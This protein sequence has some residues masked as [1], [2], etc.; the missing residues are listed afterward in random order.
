M[1]LFQHSAKQ[2]NVLPGSRVPDDAPTLA[3]VRRHP[4]LRLE[5]FLGHDVI[6]G[7]FYFLAS[8][9]VTKLPYPKPVNNR[10]GRIV[11][12]NTRR[13]GLA[14]LIASALIGAPIS[15]QE[16]GGMKDEKGMIKDEKDA[17]TKDKMKAEKEGSSRKYR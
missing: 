1:S 8:S 15:A 9:T 5:L 4:R 11:M 3:D 16:K 7:T 14:L 6:V 12:K 2:H 17:M 13:L 10:G